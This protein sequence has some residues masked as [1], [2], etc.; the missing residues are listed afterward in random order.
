MEDHKQFP[1]TSRPSTRQALLPYEVPTVTPL[2]DEQILEELGPAHAIYGRK[3]DLNAFEFE[4]DRQ[5]WDV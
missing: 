5:Y 1:Q 3:P 2:T 4:Q